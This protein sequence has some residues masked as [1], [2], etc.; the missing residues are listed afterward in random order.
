MEEFGH[1][2]NC[3]SSTSDPIVLLEWVVRVESYEWW[4]R[5]EAQLRH[6]EERHEGKSREEVADVE[7]EQHGPG[8]QMAPDFQKIRALP[9]GRAKQPGRSRAL[10]P[11]Q[12]KVYGV[13]EDDEI[14]LPQGL[15]VTPRVEERKGQC[16]SDQAFH[17]KESPL[18]WLGRG[19]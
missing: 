10:R 5:Q 11:E 17:L 9:Q 7:S 12:S 8:R 13:A 16:G 2:K 14:L 19:R 6:K 15:S 4:D 18:G 3:E 1:S